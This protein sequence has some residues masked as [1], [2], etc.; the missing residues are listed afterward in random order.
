MAP[1]SQRHSS[2][3]AF[4]YDLEVN[5]YR[6]GQGLGRAIVTAGENYAREQGAGS[7]PLHVFG[8][9]A[10]AHHLYESLGYEVT[11]VMMAKLLDSPSD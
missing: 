11:N 6:R 5:Q 2:S 4:I 3:V 9:N 8:D 10:V 1:C 7:L